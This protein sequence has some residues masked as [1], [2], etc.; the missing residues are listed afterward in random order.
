MNSLSNNHNNKTFLMFIRQINVILLL[1]IY[2]CRGDVTGLV[3]YSCISTNA[4]IFYDT[5]C[6]FY[7][8]ESLLEIAGCNDALQ[9]SQ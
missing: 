4:W 7:G 9:T 8:E 2:I 1:S 3:Y 5:F 6:P